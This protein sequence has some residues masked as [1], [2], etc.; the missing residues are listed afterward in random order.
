MSEENV[1]CFSKEE[2]S[3]TQDNQERAESA[4]LDLP[5]PNKRE[6]EM[7]VV[8]TLM[9]ENK[10]PIDDS[11]LINEGSATVM[12]LIS[13]VKEE[14]GNEDYL[15]TLKTENP[16]L[17][18][19]SIKEE[20]DSSDINYQVKQEIED[21]RMC[22]TISIETPL[23]NSYY[24][25]STNTIVK[26]ELDLGVTTGVYYQELDPSVC[27]YSICPIEQQVSKD[28]PVL[29]PFHDVMP[30]DKYTSKRWSKRGQFLCKMCDYRSNI[31]MD[32]TIHVERLHSEKYNYRCFIC[33]TI[34]YDEEVKI[35]SENKIRDPVEITYSQ[36][37]HKS[38]RALQYHVGTVHRGL[39]LL[40]CPNCDRIFPSSRA[41][42]THRGKAHREK[43]FECRYCSFKYESQHLLDTHWSTHVNTYEKCPICMKKISQVRINSRTTECPVQ[44]KERVDEQIGETLFLKQER[45]ETDSSELRVDE[46][47]TSDGKDSNCHDSETKEES[48]VGK[49]KVRSFAS[50][51]ELKPASNSPQDPRY[52]GGADTDQGR[53][54]ARMPNSYVPLKIPFLPSH[55]RAPPVISAQS[56][57]GPSGSNLC[58]VSSQIVTPSSEDV[59]EDVAVKEETELDLP[60]NS[61]TEDATIDS[62]STNIIVKDEVD[63]G[64]TTGSQEELSPNDFGNHFLTSDSIVPTPNVNIT[65]E[66]D[67]NNGESSERSHQLDLLLIPEDLR[68]RYRDVDLEDLSPACKPKGQFLCYYCDFRYTS[69]KGMHKHKERL[70]SNKYNYRCFLCNNFRP[71][72][73][74]FPS[75][76]LLEYHVA[77]VHRGEKRFKCAKCQSCYK[78][79]C[80]LKNHHANVCRVD[81]PYACHLCNFTCVSMYKLQNHISKVHDDTPEECS[82][83]SKLMKKSEMKRHLY[84]HNKASVKKC[85]K[86]DFS[87]ASKAKM[88]SHYNRT[89]HNRKY[90]C[91]LCGWGTN[92]EDCFTKHQES[93]NAPKSK[94]FVCSAPDCGK[95]FK[96]RLNFTHHSRLH[97]LPKEEVFHCPAE[98]CEYTVMIHATLMKHL[99]HTKHHFPFKCPDCTLRFRKEDSMAAHVQ[100]THINKIIE[101]LGFPL[102]VEEDDS[103]VA[104]D[105]E[106]VEDDDPYAHF[107]KGWLGMSCFDEEDMANQ[108]SST[109]DA[110]SSSVPIETHRDLE[111]ASEFTHIIPE[112]SCSVEYGDERGNVTDCCTTGGDGTNFGST[113]NYD[114]GSAAT[115]QVDFTDVSVKVE[116]DDDVNETPSMDIVQDQVITEED[117]EKL[118]STH[119]S[120]TL[121]VSIKH[122]PSENENITVIPCP[123]KF[124]ETQNQNMDVPSD[125]I[126]SDPEEDLVDAN[127]ESVVVT[128]SIDFLHF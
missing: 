115:A 88:T 63:L 113:V 19:V 33:A 28:V 29:D 45:D 32:I 26:T 124:P 11:R 109:L 108:P 87:T 9:E 123:C 17:S 66:L 21:E 10:K 116:C 14:T 94:L 100:K 85:V 78:T 71:D 99:K 73:I 34:A 47:S 23:I 84:T 114:E 20:E 106:D 110:A 49:L 122:D 22:E 118:N 96:N 46:T 121:D 36:Y 13:S 102:P 89:F 92:L 25:M 74:R 76:S 2:M 58:T 39:K 30:K 70:H 103:N 18:V 112:I 40:L 43:L 6:E 5:V 50:L 126:K 56:D 55:S 1:E 107:K 104:V 127:P 90:I 111:D 83:C 53:P 51:A 38:L 91:E 59:M 68:S 75:L 37:E 64:V 95:K 44:D 41:L 79:K 117:H 98:D 105:Q 57:D 31:M 61:T 101:K 12:K 119:D 72:S 65:T 7:E 86:C 4:I 62:T 16:D 35:R 81:D 125:Y 69:E 42:K 24:S 82:I 8:E 80:G 60:G 15:Q 48:N 3:V 77:T 54:T 67:T 52:Y 97:N 27:S 120:G 93:C 128:P